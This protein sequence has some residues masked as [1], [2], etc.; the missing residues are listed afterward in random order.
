M[1]Y[2]ASTTHGRMPGAE[3]CVSVFPHE[4]MKVPVGEN[5]EDI[6]M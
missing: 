3:K 6:Q 1:Y 2:D 5:A 4:M